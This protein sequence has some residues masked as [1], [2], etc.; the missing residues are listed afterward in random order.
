VLTYSL[1]YSVPWMKR[2]SGW[3]REVLAGWKVSDMTTIQT[4]GSLN[5]GLSTS[6]NG[7]ATRPDQIAPVTSPHTMLEWFSGKSFAQPAPGFYGDVGVGTIL[8]PGLVVFNMAAYKDFRLHERFTL[9]FRS[10]FF[11]AFNHPNFG[12]PNTNFGAGSFG[13][14]TSMKNPRIGELALKLRF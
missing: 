2:S 3:K 6:H 10:E 14:I 11:N 7:L 1:I 9:Q 12:A 5:L 8:S 4:G 13:Q